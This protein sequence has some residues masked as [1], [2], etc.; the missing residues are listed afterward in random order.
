[1]RRPLAR[2][3]LDDLAFGLRRPPP[4]LLLAESAVVQANSA[5]YGWTTAHW[6]TP[7]TA[8]KAVGPRWFDLPRSVRARVNLSCALSPD[9]EL[10]DIAYAAV[11]RHRFAAESMSAGPLRQ[12]RS[13]LVAAVV[14][15]ALAVGVVAVL[16][17]RGGGDSNSDIDQIEETIRAVT[18]I[19]LPP[20]VA[21]E[22]VCA[23]DLEA[24]K[25][26]YLSVYQFEL[27]S[28][29]DIE[30]RGEFADATI[31]VIPQSLPGVKEVDESP[32]DRQV[33]LAKEDGRWKACTFRGA[34][35]S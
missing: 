17:L 8:S 1:M 3:S 34:P 29:G 30:I 11:A 23:K 12:R 24:P 35:T 5:D 14:G 13:I 28:I 32:A 2:S 10:A 4:A 7:L 27:H 20:E 26:A 21:A 33:L 6:T 9:S 16:L 18:R 19:D 22:Y 31:K 15:L 25:G